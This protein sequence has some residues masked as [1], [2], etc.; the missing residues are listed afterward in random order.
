MAQVSRSGERHRP[1]LSLSITHDYGA[2]PG[3]CQVAYFL[4]F[5]LPG[6]ANLGLGDVPIARQAGLLP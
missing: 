4:L 1:A 3:C 5:P 2:A 6:W